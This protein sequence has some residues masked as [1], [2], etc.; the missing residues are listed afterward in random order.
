MYRFALISLTLIWVSSCS[1]TGENEAKPEAAKTVTVPVAQAAR[2]DLSREV[3]LS[4]EFRPFQEVEIHAKVSGYLK[5]IYVDVGDRVK[6]GQTLAVLEIPEME[7]DLARATATTRRSSSEVQR[8]REELDRAQAAHE[9]T[10]KSYE[11]LAAVIKTRPN[12]VAQQEIDDALARDRTSEAAV[13]AAKAAL[14]SAQQQV[15]VSQADEAKTKTL[16]A[17]ARI[18]APFAGVISKRYE[19]TGA[20]V[21]AGT[22]SQSQPLVRLSQ[23]DLLRLILPVPE[24]IVPKI[25]IG[26]PVEVRVPTLNR[27]FKGKVARFAER[28]SA[29][30][31]TMETE[32]DVPNKSMLLIPGMY[33]EAVLTTEQRPK[34]LAIPLQAVITDGKRSTVY[35]I[36]GGHR[37]EER[38]VT[39]GLETPDKVEVLSGLKTGDLV[40]TGGRTQLKPG[41]KVNP[42]IME[43]ANTSTTKGEQ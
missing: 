24:S 18:T 7:S 8:E 15:D 1:R 37:I 30:T 32:V 17:Y 27:T 11:R 5:K 40:V 16:N 35:L 20:M 29:A 25:R 22:A 26:S 3:A 10:H 39:L 2:V 42:K 12:L 34:A 13:S 14:A 41:A 38:L 19:D 6:T 28:V 43:T 21:Q 23:N 9:A 33:A 4:A 36:D 31:R